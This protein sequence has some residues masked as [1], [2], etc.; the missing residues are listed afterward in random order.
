[1]YAFLGHESACDVLR[2]LSTG[3][4]GLGL[5]PRWPKS[6]R[7]LPMTGGCVASQRDV[8][9]FCAKTSLPELGLG[10]GE[11]PLDLLV[12][13]QEMRSS[14]KRA[15]FHVWS[16]PLP[17][18]S[19]LRL[20]DELLVSGPELAIIQLCSAQGKLDA[21]LD[22]HV[23]AVRAEERVI[24]EAGL[25]ERPTCDPP[26]EW[27]RIRR[28][29]AATLVTCE[30]AGTYRLAGHGGVTYH[31]APLTTIKRLR[32]CAGEIGDFQGT[33][34]ARRVCDIAFD[35]SASPMETAVALILTLPL[36]F[37]GYGLEKPLLNHAI[38][39]SGWR[40][41]PLGVDAI[42]PDL[43]WPDQR[44]V[45]EYDSAEFHPRD[46]VSRLGKDASRANALTALGWR[47]F[48]ATPRLVGTIPSMTLL[49]RQ[50]ACALDVGLVTPTPLQAIRRE[51]LFRQLMP[52]VG[53]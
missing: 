23:E 53:A 40:D 37:G 26:L 4:K 13:K 17:A 9:A 30:F 41:V 25:D 48:R 8:K 3:E 12:P 28:L 43:L 6:P 47:V 49:A 1:M 19:C 46:D 11:R 20:T 31:A 51:K 32:C 38:D 50:L 29:V 15:T 16:R 52:K 45:L 24:A 42:T 2:L 21:L 36:D 35:G 22:A 7:R 5:T 34:R 27:E 33:R 39:V 14:G 18:G 10:L 44:I